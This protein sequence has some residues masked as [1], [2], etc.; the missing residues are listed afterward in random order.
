MII[1]ERK[2]AQSVS[3]DYQCAA[4]NLDLSGVDT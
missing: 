4:V 3:H 2:K 1:N